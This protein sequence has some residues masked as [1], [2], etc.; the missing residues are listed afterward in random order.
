VSHRT[1]R[2]TVLVVL[3]GRD[4]T[5]SGI[6]VEVRAADQFG[7]KAIAEWHV[8]ADHSG[9]LVVGDDLSVEPTGLALVEHALAGA[10]P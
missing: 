8:P 10:M 5:F 7:D 6:E 2:R 3:E 1:T 9:P 4:N